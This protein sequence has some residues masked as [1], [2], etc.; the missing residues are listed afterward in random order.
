MLRKQSVSSWG[1][2]AVTID[3][4]LNA[5]EEGVRRLKIE[6]DMYFGGGAKQPPRDTEWRVQSFVKRL[7]DGAKLTYAQRFRYNSVVQKYAVFSDLWRQKLKIREEGYRRPQDAYLGIQGLRSSATAEPAQ[8][9]KTQF[10]IS[11]GEAEAASVADLFNTMSKARQNAGMPASGT[12]ESFNAFVREKTRHI[13]QQYNCSSVEYT[14]E[15]QDGKVR[16]KAKP[17]K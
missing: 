14:V 1:F 6:Y 10:V 4:E 3:E 9:A 5:L 17:R 15:V 12:L 11:D 16:L 13:R 8:P 7:G 2:D